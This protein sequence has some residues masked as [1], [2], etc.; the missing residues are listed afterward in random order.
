MKTLFYLSPCT[1][2]CLLILVFTTLSASNARCGLPFKRIFGSIKERVVHVVRKIGSENDHY[3]SKSNQQ[4]PHEREL[5]YGAPPSSQSPLRQSSNP[6][7][8]GRNGSEIIY[9]APAGEPS[10]VLRNPQSSTTGTAVVTANEQ[11]QRVD[12]SK[13]S[14]L[15]ELPVNSLS[16]SQASPSNAVDQGSKSPAGTQASPAT[17]PISYARSIAGHPGFVY[18]PG[19]KAELKN[20]L[21]V[22]GCAS[23][24]K[25]RD[26]RTGS[27]FL[28]P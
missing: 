23:G 15:Q 16:D 17:T 24:E 6:N 9:S 12:S 14:P 11:S 8:S 22:R 10:I 21:D 25:M 27:V 5:E 28:L 2:G 3:T 18:P 19:V 13:L 1:R 26:P 20:M 7:D 4:A